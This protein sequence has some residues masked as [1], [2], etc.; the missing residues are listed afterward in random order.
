MKFECEYNK[1]YH[2]SRH[3]KKCTWNVFILYLI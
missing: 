2:F 3:A 1:Y